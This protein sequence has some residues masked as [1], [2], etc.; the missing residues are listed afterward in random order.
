VNEDEAFIRAIVDNPGDDTPRLVYA[1]WLDDRDD[2]R[3]PYLREE[4][5]VVN[6]L[7]SREEFG[8]PIDDRE[9]LAAGLDPVWVA[10]VSRPAVGVCCD[11]VRFDKCGRVLR[12]DDIEHVERQL[13]GLFCANY[14][15]F[16]LNYNGGV[17]VPACLPYPDPTWADMDMDIG[18]FYAIGTPYEPTP[19]EESEWYGNLKDER[20]WLHELYRIGGGENNNPLITGMVQ[21]A[22]TPNDLGYLLIGIAAENRGRIYHFRDYCHFSNDP[23]HLFDYCDTFAA[24]LSCLRSDRNL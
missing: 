23:Q 8:L 21:F 17:P 9:E 12:P 19:G 2:P 16:L 5:A 15:A 22:D 24:F 18:E 4:L 6:H 13:G 20:D 1:D 11:R 3:G 10:R 14:R 7:R